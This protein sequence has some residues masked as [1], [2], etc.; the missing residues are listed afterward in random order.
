MK[1]CLLAA[2]LTLLAPIAQA[3]AETFLCVGEHATGFGWS[4]SG[5]QVSE[6]SVAGSIFVVQPSGTLDDYTVTRIG[7]P[8]PSHYCPVLRR[9]D[10][11]LLLLCGG[12]GN[13]FTF[14]SK[15]L[16]FQENY[17]IGYTNAGDSNANR[18]Y[19]L[20][21]KCTKLELRGSIR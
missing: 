10:A 1:S 15:T 18:P 8:E 9:P 5:W 3:G 20:I 14:S 11:S 7:D 2:W 19:L 13:G 21:G 6:I 12:L 17:G 16:R 4:E